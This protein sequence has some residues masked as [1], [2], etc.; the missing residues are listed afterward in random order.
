MRAKTKS[1][2]R[3]PLATLERKVKGLELSEED[4]RFGGM[5]HDVPTALEELDMFAYPTL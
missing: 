1:L 4:F 2:I 3:K 5:T